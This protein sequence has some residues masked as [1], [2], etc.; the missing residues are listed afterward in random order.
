[1]SEPEVHR[2][3]ALLRRRGGL[4][5]GGEERDVQG[6]R[7]ARDPLRG[8]ARRPR[9]A[10]DAVDHRGALRPGH[11]RQGRAD[12]RRPVLRARRAAS[13][14]AMSARKRRSADR[15]ACCAT[16]T[17]SRSTPSTA[18]IDVNS[19]QS[20]TRRAARSPGSRGETE[21]TSG[22]LWKYAQQ[23]GPAVNGAVTHPGG[24]A[25]KQCYAD[26]RDAVVEPWPDRL[27][28]RRCARRRR[29]LTARARR[30]WRPRHRRAGA[31]A[32]SAAPLARPGAGA[33]HPPSVAARPLPPPAADHAVRGAS[34]RHPGAAGRAGR[35]RA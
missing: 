30:R 16:A 25:E 29:A 2:S 13:A 10:R 26:A 33:R 17:S 32:G 15:S 14:S 27:G 21:F 11:G 7:S 18:R 9:H 8:P 31:A 35:A 23:V 1:M 28:V 4:L 22:Y 12:H 24:A 34:L 20:R 5:R 19:D 6:R 3:G